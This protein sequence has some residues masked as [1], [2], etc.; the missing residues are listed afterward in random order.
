MSNSL[1][2]VELF[3][4][5]GGM[6]LGT[7]NAEFEHL[8]LVEWH[9]PAA[10]ILRHNAELHP[11]LWNK[12]DVHEKDVRIWLKQTDLKE[13]Q[14]DLVAGGPPC[15]PFSLAGVHAGDDDD[16]N[17]FPAAL[18]V[19]RKLRPKFV[20]FENVPGLT[21]P[22]FSPYFSYIRHQL[23][24]PTVTPTEDELWAEHDARI[25]KARPRS[26][27]YHVTQH[28]IDAADFGLP[29][30]RRRVFL[31]GIRT[32]L[33]NA[34]TWPDKIDGE[35]S[36]DALLYD[37][38]VTGDYWTSHGMAMPVLP[39]GMEERKRELK[40]LGRP[41]KARWQTIRDAVVGLPEPVNGVDAEGVTNHRGIPGARAYPKHSGSPFDWPAKTIKAGVHGVSG[42]EAMI[43]FDDN[44]L[45][46]LTVRESARIQGFPDDYEF[47]VARSRSMGAIGNAVAVPIAELLARRLRNHVGL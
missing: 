9:K 6:A 31:I 35:F 25:K 20:I 12:D 32:D 4:G 3:A 11:N 29:Q 41:E 28:L 18:D 39:D 5:G 34:D 37:Q 33:P 40:E 13:G 21:R 42:G 15:Q 22:S 44:S 14:V 19:V 45:R 24:K 38:W 26:L 17:M 36:R 30:N 10:T 46:Y 47:P 27:R 43:R 8:A 16:R 1:T 7:R 2:S 23:E